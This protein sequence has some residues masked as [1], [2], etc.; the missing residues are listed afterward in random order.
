ML[1]IQWL[2]IGEQCEYIAWDRE[3]RLSLLWRGASFN[4]HC[5]GR[6]GQATNHCRGEGYMNMSVERAMGNDWKL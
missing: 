1:R 5:Q 4:I 6:E 2:L 3:N